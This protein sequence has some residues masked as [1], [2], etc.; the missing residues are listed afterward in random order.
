[1]TALKPVRGRFALGL[2]TECLGRALEDGARRVTRTK[3]LPLLWKVV[4]ELAGGIRPILVA[5]IERLRHLVQG[6]S[7]QHLVLPTR[8][9]GWHVADLVIHLRMSCEAVLISLSTLTT[10]AP[11]RDFV[12]YWRD[13]PPGEGPGFG[14]VRFLWASSAAYSVS[15]GLKRHFDDTAEAAIGAV[16]SAPVGRVR[17]QGHVMDVADLLVMWTTEFAVHHLDLLAQ[18]D[19]CP[20]PTDDALEVA[21]AT[22]DGLIQAPR[23]T[24]WDLP[25]YVLKATGRTAL[26]SN[27]KSSLGPSATGYPALG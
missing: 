20:G 6:L 10:D 15:S 9:T 18:I 14:E 25:T 4:L 11:D 3:A 21:A 26:L 17:F 12:T 22:L 5:E 8:C 7:D 2:T 24:W 27:E 13:W 19:N 23:P 1:M 16:R